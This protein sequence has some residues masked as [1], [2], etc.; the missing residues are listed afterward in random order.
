MLKV[1]SF[2]TNIRTE[3]FAPLI[4]CVIDYALLE[5]MPDIDLQFIGIMTLVDPLLHFCPHFIVNRVQICAV[6]RLKFWWNERRC[7]PFQKVDCLARSVSRS[8]VLLKDEFSRTTRSGFWVRSTLSTSCAIDI[9]YNIDENHFHSPKLDVS[10]DTITDLLKVEC[11]CS[12]HS[13]T[14]C[15]SLLSQPAHRRNFSEDF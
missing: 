14:T 12:R 15:I 2:H 11:G 9:H 1:S 10:M 7:L 8:I 5:T 4:N 6:G 13:G 3:T